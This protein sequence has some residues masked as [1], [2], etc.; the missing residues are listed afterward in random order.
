MRRR[1]VIILGPTAV[2]KTDYSIETALGYGSPVISCDSRQI[3]KHMTIGTAVPSPAQL[4]A[5]KHYFIQTKELTELYTAGKY[6]IEALDLIGRL[7]DEGHETLVAC[8][9]SMF[10]IDALVGGIAPTPPADP[11]VRTTLQDRL[12]KEGAQAL[13]S[14]LCATDPEIS[15]TI[16]LGNMRKVLR[17]LEVMTITG[18]PYSSFKM[19][20]PKERDFE[21]EKVGLMRPRE[22]LYARID[23]RVEKMFAD[24]LIDEVRSLNG[25][26][27]LSA[28]QTVGY[29][30]VFDY[31]DGTVSLD[32]TVSLVKRNTRHYAKRQLTWWRRDE[33]IRW[34]NL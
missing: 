16:D 15:R 19:A 17:A 25:F 24:G 28:L 14:E 6:E 11:D 31:L 21:I 8:G 3:Y 1:L 18:R 13:V 4:S 29:R 10:Y 34:I 32:E 22:E 2:G 5:V 7:F 26:R 12:E 30:E 9:G 27:N 20:S 23:A 33:S